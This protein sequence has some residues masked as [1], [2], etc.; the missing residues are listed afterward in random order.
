MSTLSTLWQIVNF[1]LQ[2]KQNVTDETMAR[3]AQAHAR[4]FIA[5]FPTTNT[6]LSNFSISKYG[7]WYEHSQYT[8]HHHLVISTG[9]IIQQA[10]VMEKLCLEKI[11]TGP[12]HILSDSIDD[13]TVRRY[14]F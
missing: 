2:C 1:P 13:I 6:T 4:V 7:C 5:S 12:F 8:S 9:D 11:T 10:A 3:K 14:K